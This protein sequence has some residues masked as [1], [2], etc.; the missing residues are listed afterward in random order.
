MARLLSATVVS[1]SPSL[2]CPIV[3]GVRGPGTGPRRGGTVLARSTRLSHRIPQPP[4]PATPTDAGIPRPRV[5]DPAM[6]SAG[7][8]PTKSGRSGS[9]A[10]S[11]H[12][13]AMLSRQPIHAAPIPR[14]HAAPK[15]ADGTL[16]VDDRA[17]GEQFT[18]YTPRFVSQFRAGHRAGLWY[19]RPATDVGPAPR[20]PG[21]A[22]AR[23]AVEALRTTSWPPTA[24][25]PQRPRTR[26]RVGT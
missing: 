9:R 16:L 23:D 2:R 4:P 7:P 22:T 18:V 25:A 8:K 19:L 6:R 5:V 14:F 1:S 12:A 17:S 3:S 10:S 20:S 11:A 26:L 21:F 13:L 24:P 15:V